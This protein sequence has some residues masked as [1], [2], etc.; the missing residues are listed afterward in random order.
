MKNK[1]VPFSGWLL[2][3][4][5][6]LRNSRSKHRGRR[7]FGTTP[8]GEEVWEYTLTNSHGLVLKVI[9]YGCT[10]TSLQVP[11]R[12]GV[13]E[14][15]VLGFDDLEGYLQSGASMGCVVGRFA[16]RIAHG[17]FSLEGKEYTLDTNLPPHHLHGGMKGFGRVVW[18]AEEFQNEKGVGIIFRYLSPDGEEGYPGNLQVEVHYFLGDDDTLS[19]EYRAVT[20]QKTI[21]N[22]TQHSYFNLNGGKENIHDHQLSIDADSFL[23]VDH[24]MIPTGEIAP[25]KGTPFDFT[26]P[27]TVGRD[28]GLDHPQLLIGHGY[29]HCWVF[30]PSG[31]ELPHAATLYDEFSGRRMEVYTTSPGMQ[32]YTSNFLNENPPGKKNIALTPRLGICLET[33]HFPDSP[34]HPEFPSVVLNAGEKHYSKTMLTFS[35]YS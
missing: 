21:I 30:R 16:N 22:L 14:D 12:N 19:F 35:T 28:I 11:D 9:S 24:E 1:E 20:D 17:K 29:D 34:N 23:I 13:L 31:E 15:I 10:I 33:Q 7:H 25:V 26:I 6:R 8:S 18:D 27:K 32:V 4:S 5:T 2:S 3:C